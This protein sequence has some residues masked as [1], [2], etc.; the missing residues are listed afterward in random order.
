[1]KFLFRFYLNGVKQ[2]WTDRQRVQELKQS[3][4]TTGRRLVWSEQRLMRVHADDLKKL[5]LFLAILIILE[6]ILPL[7]VIYAPSLLPS[8]CILPSQLLKIRQTEEVKRAAA[9][10]RLRGTK[11]VQDLMALAGWSVQQ[12]PGD[13][14]DT[15][16]VIEKM[17]P[18][19]GE[20]GQDISAKLKTLSK[21]TLIDFSRIF[22]LGTALR[23]ASWMRS[24]LE[25]HMAFLTKD[26]DALR[27]GGSGDASSTAKSPDYSQVPE[28]GPVLAEISSQRG[29][30]CCELESSDMFENLRD[31]LRVTSVFH[32][33]AKANSK[34]ATAATATATTATTPLASP[35]QMLFLPLLL[36]PAP[37]FTPSLKQLQAREESEAQ[38]GILE[39]SKE[40][41]Q[42]VIRAE[43]VKAQREADVEKQSQDK[44]K[45]RS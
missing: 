45:K 43:E 3:V 19:H 30:R 26:D 5:P 24:Q 6:E 17:F 13:K 16:Q 28:S 1:M 18:L 34:S 27:G 22:A 9:I 32:V 44:D 20:K 41:A 14:Q 37:L 15:I 36:Y 35:L 11:E 25:A 21:D 23:P 31:W 8:T 33:A 29:M 40:V 10:E 39:R 7:V 2:I 38:K 4:Q 42:E 12:K